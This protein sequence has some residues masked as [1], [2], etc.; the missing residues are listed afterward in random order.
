MG[1]ASGAEKWA[2]LG[3][4][5]FGDVPL[6]ASPVVGDVVGGHDALDAFDLR[7]QMAVV[8]REAVLASKPARPEGNARFLQ[9]V[10]VRRERDDREAVELWGLAEAD[11]GAV[12]GAGAVLGDDGVRQQAFRKN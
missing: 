11:V 7:R 4:G 5:V 12:Q 1:I 3:V 8:L 10:R 6:D 2:S 9:D